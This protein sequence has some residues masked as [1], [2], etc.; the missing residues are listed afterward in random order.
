M[1]GPLRCGKLWEVQ[2][3]TDW[4]PGITATAR[5]KHMGLNTSSLVKASGPGEYVEG[6]RTCDGESHRATFLQC[7]IPYRPVLC[8]L[9]TKSCLTLWGPRDCSPPGSSVH[10]I[11]QAR[12]LEQ[13]AISFSRGLPKP[14]I[15]PKAGGQG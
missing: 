2:D 14:G 11:S 3:Q 15:G 9:V 6:E 7:G 1:L 13:V 4:L 12:L 10:G 5:W 8:C